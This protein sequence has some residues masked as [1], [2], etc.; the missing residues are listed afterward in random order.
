MIR[1]VLLPALAVCF[2]NLDF[3]IGQPPDPIAVFPAQ[4]SAVGDVSIWDDGSE[5]MV[6]IGEITHGHFSHYGDVSAEQIHEQVAA[7]VVAF[8]QDLFADRV[9][10]WKS[11]SGAGGWKIVGADERFSLL[12]PGDQTYLWSGPVENSINRNDTGN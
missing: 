10:L 7:G 2:P 3:Q 6:G 9:L 5:A 12:G 8:L 11:S 4:H 1:D